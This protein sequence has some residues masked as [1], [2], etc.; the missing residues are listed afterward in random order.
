M[1]FTGGVRCWNGPDR[2]A[3]VILSC[4]AENK[5]LSVD[6]PN[7]CEYE[8]KFQTP[9]VCSEPEEL[10]PPSEHDEL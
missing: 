5:V 7:R 8:Y 2:S 6:E 4:G 3:K 10:E 9:A 1:M